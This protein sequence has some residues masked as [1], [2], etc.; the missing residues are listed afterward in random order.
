MHKV[1]FV[2]TGNHP[3]FVPPKEAAELADFRVRVLLEGTKEASSILIFGLILLTL[4]FL[5][6][7]IGHRRFPAPEAA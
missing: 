5:L 6:V 1:L 2:A 3:R 7:A 4:T